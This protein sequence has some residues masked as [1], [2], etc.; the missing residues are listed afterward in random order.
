MLSNS[1]PRR[2]PTIVGGRGAQ[3]GSPHRQRLRPRRPRAAVVLAPVRHLPGRHTAHRENGEACVV[4]DRQ[5]RPPSH[6][7]RRQR[8]R[9]PDLQECLWRGKRPSGHQDR[10]PK[11]RLPS[12][13]ELHGRASRSSEI[14]VDH[15]AGRR[16]P[17][18]GN[19]RKVGEPS[20]EPLLFRTRLGLCVIDLA[21][22]AHR[23]GTSQVITRV[24]REAVAGSCAYSA[25]DVRSH[26]L[27]R[28]TMA[29]ADEDALAALV[30][31]SGLRRGTM[32]AHL[33]DDLMTSAKTSEA[34]LAQVLT[35]DPDAASAWRLL[36]PRTPASGLG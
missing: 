35:Q 23:V 16:H 12:I 22:D 29:Q 13:R 11:H 9:V 36:A 27:C 25:S 5:P 18:A 19:S 26:E 34:Q 1:R 2:G 4:T 15:L 32:P 17:R 14:P 3:Q 31:I 33:L 21:A 7:Q 24:I 28:S 20:R 10:R 6:A 8:L 30:Q